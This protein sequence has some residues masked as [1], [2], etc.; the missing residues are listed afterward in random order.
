MRCDIIF[1]FI[2]ID[3]DTHCFAS[4]TAGIEQFETNHAILQIHLM[5]NIYI[6][7]NSFIQ[8]QLYRGI[9]TFGYIT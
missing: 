4:T 2:Q 1:Q 6:S 9:L 7:I 8:R 3:F 5:C